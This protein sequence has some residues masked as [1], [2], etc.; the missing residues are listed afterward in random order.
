MPSHR[1]NKPQS[2]APNASPQRRWTF[3]AWHAA[4]YAIALS[5]AIYFLHE[6]LPTTL[7]GIVIFTAGWLLS[8][9]LDHRWRPQL[10]GAA[11]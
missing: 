8:A 5:V 9:Y 7:I 4:A 11:L 10:C 2:A 1:E 3:W 6:D